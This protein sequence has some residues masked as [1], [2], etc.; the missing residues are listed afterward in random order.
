M[1]IRWL[2]CC[3]FEAPRAC[4]DPLRRVGNRARERGLRNFTTL[5]VDYRGIAQFTG[6]C[7]ERVGRSF[8]ELRGYQI[9][10]TAQV[11]VR[12]LGRTG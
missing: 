11:I 6:S 3:S 12:T 8:R 7:A 10:T 9:P 5:W 2:L 4:R 1:E